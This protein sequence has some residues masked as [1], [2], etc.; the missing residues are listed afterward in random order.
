MSTTIVIHYDQVAALKTHID[1]KIERIVIAA[2]AD[3]QR[4][5]PVATGVLRSS[6]SYVRKGP[7]SYSII[8]TAPYAVYVEL[9]TSRMAA[10]PYLRPAL[11]QVRKI[12][13][14]AAA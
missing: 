4:Y 14:V 12:A 2:T 11:Y 5:A 3:A 6:I 7:G 9:G 10:Q 8:A 13:K 1:T